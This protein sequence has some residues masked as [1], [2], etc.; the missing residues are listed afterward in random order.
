M[1]M[2]RYHRC[3]EPEYHEGKEEQRTHA[4]LPK[5]RIRNLRHGNHRTGAGQNPANE[6]ELS[7]EHFA[8]L[9][10][11]CFVRNWVESGPTDAR[12]ISGKP[13]SR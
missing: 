6:F 9:L 12:A 4:A 13:V 2:Q 1:Q 5:A 10:V 11:G 8:N 3:G 7:V